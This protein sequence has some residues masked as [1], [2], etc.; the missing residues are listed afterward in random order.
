MHSP[1][2]PVCKELERVRCDDNNTTSPA[3]LSHCLGQLNA[4]MIC[5]RP[6]IITQMQARCLQRWDKMTTC[7]H[8]SELKDRVHYTE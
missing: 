5:T 8:R 4:L 2:V 3:L 7:R 1:P 6:A